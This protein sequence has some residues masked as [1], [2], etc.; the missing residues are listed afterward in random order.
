MFGRDRGQQPERALGDGGQARPRAPHLLGKRL[1]GA[2][3]RIVAEEGP[4]GRR[5]K[6][7][8]EQPVAGDRRLQLQAR[9]RESR[10][11]LVEARSRVLE[12]QLEQPHDACA[13]RRVR[14]F[15]RVLH[16]DRDAVAVV[17]QRGIA[18]QPLR[19]A[20]D[21][22]R[23]RQVAEIPLAESPLLDARRRRANDNCAASPNCARNAARSRP[24][25]NSPPAASTTCT[26]TARCGGMSLPSHTSA[27]GASP[28]RS[29]R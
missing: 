7:V 11:A 17:H 15:A 9:L 16:R 14:R 19:A 21:R 12:A 3:Q 1:L 8:G 29:R 23:F 20:R 6:D 18:G 13:R 28:R 2:R 27:G 22:Q 25:A 10:S 4:I 26:L 24:I 5:G